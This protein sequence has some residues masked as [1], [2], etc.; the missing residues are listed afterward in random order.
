MTGTPPPR[1]PSGHVYR[2]RSHARAG[3]WYAKYRLPDGRQ[4]Q[5]K[6]GPAWTGRGR[7]AAGDS[8]KRTAEAWWPTCCTRRATARCSR[9]YLPDHNGTHTAWVYASDR[10]GTRT[11]ASGTEINVGSLALGGITVD[12]TEGGKP[13]SAPLH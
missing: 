13:Y 10:L 2:R 3:V 5:R 7:P 9:S 4:L 12:W 1:P 6:L 11:L 8:T